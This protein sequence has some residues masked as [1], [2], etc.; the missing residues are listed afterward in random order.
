M[1]L[2]LL[3]SMARREVL[4]AGI[5]AYQQSHPTSIEAEAAGGVEVARRVAA[6]DNRE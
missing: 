4:A 6:G 1:S 3:S 2:K 5:A